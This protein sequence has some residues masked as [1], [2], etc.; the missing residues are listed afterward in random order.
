[1]DFGADIG[2]KNDL[3]NFF[4]FSVTGMYVEVGGVYGIVSAFF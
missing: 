1:M 3:S 2:K 4:D